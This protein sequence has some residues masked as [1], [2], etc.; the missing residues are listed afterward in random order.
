M[1]RFKVEEREVSPRV[2]KLTGESGP[3]Y[4]VVDTL[5][6]RAVPFGGYG[7]RKDAAVDRAARENEKE[8]NPK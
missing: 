3:V 1:S 2:R 5:T 4:F 7:S 8:E 6:R